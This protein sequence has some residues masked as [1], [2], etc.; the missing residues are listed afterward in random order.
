M[1]YK[2]SARVLAIIGLLAIVAGIAYFLYASF[3]GKNFFFGLGII[4]LVPVII[5]AIL[6]FGGA[7]KDDKSEDDDE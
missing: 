4:I 2:K 3:T 7:F 5:W 6:F 1:K